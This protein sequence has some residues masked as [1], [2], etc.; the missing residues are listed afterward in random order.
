MKSPLKRS[1][2]YTT[3][4]VESILFPSHTNRAFLERKD[5]FP[6]DKELCHSKFSH[7]KEGPG[8]QKAFMC[9]VRL[10]K[11]REL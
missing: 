5:A 10:T 9:G 6:L 11:I 4:L 1:L 3:E 7:T 8:F 2:M